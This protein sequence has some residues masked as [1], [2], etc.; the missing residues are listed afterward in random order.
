MLQS[1]L[2]LPLLM[3]SGKPLTLGTIF[4]SLAILVAAWW[5][6]RL[7]QRGLTR[8][9]RARQLGDEGSQAAGR[10]LL[11]YVIILI[12][13]SIAL[14]TA[15]IDLS[16]LFAAGAIFAVGVGFAMQN[17]AQNFVSGLILLIERSI[18]PNDVLEVE[19]TVVRVEHMGIRS[20][21]ARTRDDEELIIPNAVLV[22]STVKNFTLKDSLFRLRAVVGVTYGSNVQVVM[23]ALT[24]VGER[25]EWRSPSR[26]PR[27]LMAGFG[28]SSVDFEVSVWINDP[29]KS[30]R[31]LSDLYQAIWWALKEAGVTIAFPQVDVHF[32]PPV[33]E[34]FA[35]LGAR[36]A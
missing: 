18:K 19:G 21:V 3:I 34:S 12:G 22:Q 16:A 9:L 33:S 8:W 23:E 10:R 1:I 14:D 2:N 15:G 36:A 26:K 29:W 20:T 4:A 25:I 24:Q 13:L 32:D 5:F 17:I 7:A 27:V 28:A 31:R 35:A 11:H 30:R 6:S